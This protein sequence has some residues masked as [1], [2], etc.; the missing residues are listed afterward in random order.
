MPLTKRDKSSIITLKIFSERNLKM[1]KGKHDYSFRNQSF[2]HKGKLCPTLNAIEEAHCEIDDGW[3]I[4]LP[5]TDSRLAEY[6]SYD[7]FRFLSASFGICPKI[8][9]TEDLSTHLKA[10]KH[11]I[12]LLTEADIQCYKLDSTQEGAF[13]IDVTEDSVLIVG[14]TERGTAQG[15]YYIEDSLRLRGD[16]KL[17]QEN[18]EHA[19]LFSPRMTH[20]GTELDTFPDNFLE[21]C[22]HAGMDSIIVYAGH[23]DTNLHGFTDPDALWPGTGW[24]Y[25]DFNNLVWRA[26][27]YGLDVYIYSHIKCDVYPD[28]PDALE[29]YKASFGTLFRNCPKLKG[30]IFVGETFEFP[31]KDPHTAGIRC[32]LKPK[33]DR[34]PSP[35]WYPCSD[36]PKL[37][38]TV[39]DIIRKYNEDADIVF[40]S[41]NWGWAPK[42]ARLALIEALPSDISLL[43]T[44]EMWEY[45]ND[46][47]GAQYRIADYS[48]SF[49]GPSQV[50]K[51]EAE[52]AKELGIRLYAMGN[53]GGRTWDVGTAPYI[54]AP[55]QWQ[56]RYDALIDAKERYGLCGLMENHHYGWLPSFLDLFSKNAFTSRTVSSGEMLS[57]IARRDYGENYQKALD[58]WECFSQGISKVIAC[59]T[60]QYGPYRSGPSYPLL[61]TQTKEELNMPFVPWAWHKRG[62]IWN[63]IYPDAVLSNPEN[64]LM[65]L[66]HVNEAAKKFIEG[67]DILD[68]AASNPKGSAVSKQ[69][70]VARYISC[71][72]ITA[73]H[74]MEW[75]IAKRLLFAISEK[76]TGEKF[77]ELFKAIS[78]TD[79]SAEALA[80]RMKAIADSERKNVGVALECWREDSSIGF[81]ASM[82]Y[83]F[84]DEFADWKLTQLDISLKLLDEYLKNSLNTKHQTES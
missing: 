63:P 36:Y 12:L 37:I 52:K 1:L 17:K 71:T 48:L 81:E 18:A 49:A 38:N 25:C 27:G 72:Y 22:A 65:R 78:V 24:S 5:S 43:V 23:P 68:L 31:S 35:G 8:R 64:S 59:N 69:L 21:A 9:Y 61:F 76:L 83:V 70:A 84:N 42:E 19:P 73:K 28:D 34:R 53:T 16:S 62:G 3:E 40:W 39:K 15:V 32:Q 7:L 2:L 47:M 51:D 11:K 56:K 33:E 14:K 10:P 26:E 66:R 30:I 54:P 20:S 29:Y 75:N 74:V 6:Y 57:K 67:A 44:F 45:L 79:Q 46:D 82:E 58:A 4:V 60:D 80:D 50:F 77:D 41:Y 55:Q 13:R